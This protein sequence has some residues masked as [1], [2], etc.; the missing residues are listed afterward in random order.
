MDREAAAL[1]DG[2]PFLYVTNN[3]R[4]SQ[5][6]E[7]APGAKKMEVLSHGLNC[8]DGYHNIYFSA[9]LNREP[10]H[11]GMLRNSWLR[12]RFCP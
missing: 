5:V 1:F 4:K 11:L 7:Q 12:P 8:Y 10:R 6:L 3:D 9:A 2:K